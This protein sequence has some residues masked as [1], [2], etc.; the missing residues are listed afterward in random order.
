MAEATIII[1]PPITNSWM[2]AFKQTD[3][4]RVYFSISDYNDYDDIKYLQF[5]CVSQNTNLSIL[6]RNTYP[7]GI[8]MVDKT[9]I[10]IDNTRVG[11]DKYY[12]EISPEYLEDPEKINGNNAFQRDIN[13][14][15]QIRFA[16]IEAEDFWGNPSYNN[17]DTKYIGAW[18]N[19]NLDKLSEWSRVCIIRAIAQPIIDLYIP[20][21]P[22]LGVQE[23]EKLNPNTSNNV[24]YSFIGVQGQMGFG[25]NITNEQEQLES[26]RVVI[27]QNNTL[28]YDSLDLFTDSENPNQIYHS[29]GL[30]FEDDTSYTLTFSYVTENGYTETINYPLAVNLNEYVTLVAK[31]HVLEDEENACMAFHLTSVLQDG[32][33]YVDYNETLEDA[34][35]DEVGLLA[36]GHGTRTVFVDANTGLAKFGSANKGQIVIDPTQETALIYGGNYSVMAGTGMLIDLTTPSIKFG[37]GN[38]EIGPDGKL[39]ALSME[40]HRGTNN[41]LYYKLDQFGLLIDV[42]STGTYPY[43]D[44]QIP[45]SGH[46]KLVLFDSDTDPDSSAVSSGKTNAIAEFGDDGIILQCLQTSSYL[47][48]KQGIDQTD[49]GWNV[50]FKSGNALY[51]ESGIQSGHEPTGDGEDRVTNASVSIKSAYNANIW[52]GHGLSLHVTRPSDSSKYPDAVRDDTYGYL[53]LETQYGWMY[54]SNKAGGKKN[55]PGIGINAYKWADRQNL[56]DEELDPYPGRDYKVYINGNEV[57]DTGN[58]AEATGGDLGGAVY[59]SEFGNLRPYL[60]NMVSLGS[61]YEEGDGIAAWR[62]VVT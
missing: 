2:P 46:R 50:A 62:H 14:K 21:C 60:N 42:G 47:K 10:H 52:A 59:V 56:W 33:L 5:I 12:F 49:N 41:S 45:S 44:A 9:N 8:I 15:V 61:Y 3:S 34:Y 25:Q 48:M 36:Y 57:L 28:V 19:N 20:Y 16:S 39:K 17:G 7:A 43:P 51:L 38:F 29:I 55:T 31:I 6:S 1:Y 27:T 26:Y 40:L 54:M 37:S 4:V 18:N 24:T 11:D 53:K 13:F 35:A 22:S 30:K 32:H 58:A 23:L